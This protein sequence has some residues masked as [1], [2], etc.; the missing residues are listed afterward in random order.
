MVVL[1]GYIYVHRIDLK[2]VSLAG[3]YKKRLYKNY[4][5]IPSVHV[6]KLSTLIS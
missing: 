2:G 5:P 4:L 3:I 6:P 1:G